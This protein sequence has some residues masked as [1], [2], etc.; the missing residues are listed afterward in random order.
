MNRRLWSLTLALGLVLVAGFAMA[1]AGHGLHGVD[2]EEFD[3]AELQDGETRSFGTGENQITATR[4]GD[5]VTLSR[6]ASDEHSELQITCQVGAD[7]CKVITSDESDR[8]MIMIEK[9]RECESGAADCEAIADDMVFAE[10]AGDHHGGQVVLKK[11]IEC[12]DEDNC[13][14]L[15]WH[16]AHGAGHEVRVIAGDEGENVFVHALPGRLHWV[17]ET[18]DKT[19]LSCP[20]GDTTMRVDKD[21]TEM[22][23]LCP[24]HSVP[25]KEAEAPRVKVRARTKVHED[26]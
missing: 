8:A 6:P 9:R 22:G 15:E 19:L 14:E 10:S 23:Y 2:G 1:Q 5:V 21:E 7:T 26:N 12:T 18:S 17:E 25:L 20:E 11:I 13:E 16:G 24:K 4:D 3:L